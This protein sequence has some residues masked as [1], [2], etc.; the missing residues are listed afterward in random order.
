M[1]RDRIAVRIVGKNRP[2]DENARSGKR[3]RLD[4]LAPIVVA[5][6]Y[7]FLENSIRDKM[8][9]ISC[10]PALV[11]GDE[12]APIH[13]TGSVIGN[14]FGSVP[15]PIERVDTNRRLLARLPAAILVH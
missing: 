9:L 5:R 13:C 3:L 12:T 10:V 14:I 2:V 4:L 1:G 8:A 15:A 7:A 6:D 11:V